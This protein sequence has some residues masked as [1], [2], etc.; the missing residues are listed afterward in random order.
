MEISIAQI[1]FL[2]FGFAIV[3]P[4]FFLPTLVAIRAKHP[5]AFNIALV[6]SMFSWTIIG[7]GFAVV[8]AFTPGTRMLQAS[9]AKEADD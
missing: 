2:F 7:W 9:K 1:I 6:N 8:W 4:V 3:G 5:Q